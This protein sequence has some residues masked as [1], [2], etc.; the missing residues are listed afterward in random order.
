MT[1]FVGFIVVDAFAIVMPS[2]SL[3]AGKSTN[4]S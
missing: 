3:G 1:E 2:K 4:E